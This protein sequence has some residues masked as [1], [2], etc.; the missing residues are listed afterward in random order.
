MNPRERLLFLAHDAFARQ[1][2]VRL[3]A[4]P[5]ACKWCGQTRS[6]TYYYGIHRDDQLGNVPQ[7]GMPGPFCNQDCW[8]MWTS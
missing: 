2:V 7:R 3:A 4:G 6:H 8:R 5:G 1:S